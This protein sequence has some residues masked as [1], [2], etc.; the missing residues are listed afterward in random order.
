MKV[1]IRK[2]SGIAI[3]SL[4]VLALAASGSGFAIADIVD[5]PLPDEDEDTAAATASVAMKERCIW[6]V[7][8]APDGFTLAADEAEVSTEYD[9]TQFDLS[10]ELETPL[11]AYTSGNEGTGSADAHSD[12]T[13]Y[14]EATGVD[15]TADFT[16]VGFTAASTEGADSGMNFDPTALLPL[17]LDVAA[18]TCRTG[19][20]VSAWT[21]G[22]DVVIANAA[23]AT[24]QPMLS[25]DIAETT[26]VPSSAAGSNDKCD[27]TLSMTVAVPAGKTPLYAGTTYTFT[28]PTMTTNIDIDTTE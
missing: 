16:A 13:F 19:G 17:T 2:V 23:G 12:C 20:D 27:A 9:G 4:G 11:L 5:Q 1:N 3:A 7:T 22:P 21:V 24:A 25:H 10:V 28:G 26:A 8:G 14:G 6:Y 18:G 15:V